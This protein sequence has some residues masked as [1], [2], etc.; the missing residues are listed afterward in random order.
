MELRHVDVLEER[1]ELRR[2]LLASLALHLAVFGLI[3]A[4]SITGLGRRQ[5]WGDPNSLG[6]GG[7]YSVSPVRSIPIP[8]RSGP[9]NRV[10]AD[11]Q[12]QIPS[13]PKPEPKKAAREPEPDAIAIRSRKAPR[14]GRSPRTDVVRRDQREF[15]DNQVFSRAGQAASSPMYATAPGSGGVGLGS[16]APFGARCGGYAAILRDRVAQRWR[17]EQVDPRIR[18]LPPAVVVFELHRNGQVRNVRLVQSSGNVALD[19]S[20]QR[21]IVEAGPFEP[22]PPGCEGNPAIVE[23]WFELKR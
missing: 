22:I 10:A 6:G 20:A 3:A 9:V 12:S 13:P 11:T 2:P 16:G 23:F 15:G 8:G 1:D 19:Y 21:A 5:P 17:T 14:T 7:A 4:A 18:T